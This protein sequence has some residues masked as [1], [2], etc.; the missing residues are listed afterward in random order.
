MWKCIAKYT[1]VLRT[2][3]SL[4]LVVCQEIGRDIIH[5]NKVVY[6][7]S[8]NQ[9]TNQLTNQQPSSFNEGETDRLRH[10]SPISE[11]HNATQNTCWLQ[12]VWL[13]EWQWLL[14]PRR[15]LFKG[16]IIISRR[17]RQKYEHRQQ[18]FASQGPAV[19]KFWYHFNISLNKACFDMWLALQRLTEHYSLY[20]PAIAPVI[21][22][23]NIMFTRYSTTFLS[24]ISTSNPS[25]GPFLHLI[26][27]QE[28]T[29]NL[30][31]YLRHQFE[32]SY[33][34]ATLN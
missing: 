31:E 27:Q 34:N 15:P 3:C 25:V 13:S 28:W 7:A 26:A 16:Q 17:I 33:I 20:K 23:V 6:F 5:A 19:A 21:W 12:S 11:V 24:V 4:T 22:R 18:Q 30:N 29:R 32:V 14:P 8:A 2:P 9:P 1:A 10:K